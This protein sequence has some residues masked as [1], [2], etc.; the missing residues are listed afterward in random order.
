MA[1][2][3]H[4]DQ[5]S[6]SLI[7]GW[8][9]DPGRPDEPVS[10]SILVNGAQRGMCLTTRER[11]D[12]KL[13]NGEKITGKCAFSFNF[14]P[15]LSPF[16]ELRIDVIETWSG[17]LLPN[18]SDVLPRPRSHDGVGGG[19]VPILLTSTGRTGTTLLMSEFVRHPDIVAG[20]HFPYEIKQIAYYA[21]AFRALAADA[22]RER[23]TTPET[24]LAPELAHAIGGNPFNLSG[25]FGLGAA[26]DTLRD[27]YRNTVPSG[28]A[29]L[30]RRFI[31]EFYATL[32]RAQGKQS[33]PFICEKG[34]ID[35]AA[36]QGARLSSMR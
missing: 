29:S 26:S 6:R 2:A 31:L 36:V 35:D 5:I 8:A 13:P 34:D 3:G 11:P 4:V 27:F 7:E 16:V 20:D 32:A 18:G 14:E 30:F 10:V 15:P 25:F 33:A 22:D 19:P 17:Q 23:S 21:A 1:L 24:M 28:Y 9:I 12:L